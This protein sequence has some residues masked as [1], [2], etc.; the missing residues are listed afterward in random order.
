MTRF[1][2]GKLTRGAT[3]VGQ[4]FLIA[5]NAIRV[6]V[7]ATATDYA[8]RDILPSPVFDEQGRFVS[9]VRAR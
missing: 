8:V 1:R 6:A 5:S 9:F 7:R 3:F 4:V 2:E